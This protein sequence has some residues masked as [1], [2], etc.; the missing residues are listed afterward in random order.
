MDNPA[1]IITLDRESGRIDFDLNDINH[2]EAQDAILA[3]ARENHR[4]MLIEL[5]ATHGDGQSHDN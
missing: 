5:E 1:I 4:Q 3:V 2:A